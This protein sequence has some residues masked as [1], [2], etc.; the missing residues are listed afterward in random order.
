VTGVRTVVLA[1]QLVPIRA[2]PGQ[3]FVGP[4]VGRAGKFVD[5]LNETAK[6]WG[7]SPVT[8][9]I[10][11]EHKRLVLGGLCFFL[12]PIADL[13]LVLPTLTRSGRNRPSGEWSGDSR[14]RG[15][16]MA[17][18]RHWRISFWLPSPCLGSAPGRPAGW[19]FGVNVWSGLAGPVAALA[20]AAYLGNA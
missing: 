11:E 16:A 2:N 4:V 20:R 7:S 13:F 5:F 19:L 3:I 18:R 10:L 6:G 14:W 1:C 9:A 12:P 17:G 15:G 8:P